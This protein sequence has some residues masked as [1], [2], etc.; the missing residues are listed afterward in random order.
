MQ[1][2]EYEVVFECVSVCACACV[3]KSGLRETH[4][5]EIEGSSAERSDHSVETLNF[6]IK[7]DCVGFKRNQAISHLHS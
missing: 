2:E 5:K 3:D 7:I 6:G 1:S 4:C